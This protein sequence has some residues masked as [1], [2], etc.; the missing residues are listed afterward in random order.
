MRL[1]HAI[2]A[3]PLEPNVVLDPDEQW[4]E[5]YDDRGTWLV[6]SGEFPKVDVGVVSDGYGFEDSPDCERISGGINTKGPEAVAIGR[7]A[8]MLQWGFYGAPDRMTDSAK[9]VFL[10]ALVYMRQFDGQ[11]PLVKKTA[12][13]RSSFQRSIGY[14]AKLDEM[15]DEQRESFEEYLR[16]QFPADIL[17]EH[18]LDPAALGAWYEANEE[19][20]SSDGR[21]G[22]VVDEDLQKLAL[23]N[24]TPAFLDVITE[25]LSA[26]APD[27]ITQRL[28]K[29]YFGAKLAKDP[30]ELV[31]WIEENRAWL[32]FSDQGG[33]RWFVDENA[34]GLAARPVEAGAGQR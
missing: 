11:R 6:H 27:K 30:A 13:G 21:Y 7:Q 29:R 16:G 18:G 23:S 5:E 10:N 25:R 34:K 1:E 33:F 3:G 24:R 20:M 15:D 31:D 12:R 8:N 17:A 9:K 22:V 19:Y 4:E 28:A 2:F 14:I 26:G 32:F